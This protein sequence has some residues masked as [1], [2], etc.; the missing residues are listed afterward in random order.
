M[1]VCGKC[2]VSQPKT[3][4]NKNGKYLRSICKACDSANYQ[5]WISQNK[6]HKK[7]LDRK[8]WVACREKL[9]AQN[10]EWVRKNRARKNEIDRNRHHRKLKTLGDVPTNIKE[11]LFLEQE[12][13]CFYCKFSLEESHLEH[14]VPISRG[15]LHDRSNLCL[16]CPDCNLRKGTKTVEEFG[17]VM[18]YRMRM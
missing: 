9:L 5:R 3:N 6:Q 1:K 13:I 16:S 7:I 15:G 10:K 11:I 14:K 8:R 4:F 2:E 17:E 18:S 12:G